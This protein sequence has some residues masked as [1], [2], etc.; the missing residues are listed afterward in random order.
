MIGLGLVGSD[1]RGALI[2]YRLRIRQLDA[3]KHGDEGDP[4]GRHHR[5][6][7]PARVPTS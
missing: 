7:T 4:H 1:A 2:V 3:H 6:R 5:R